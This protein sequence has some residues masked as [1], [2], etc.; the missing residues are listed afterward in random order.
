MNKKIENSLDYHEKT[1]HS[2][3]SVMNS[4]HYLDWNNRPN[5]FKIYVNLTSLTLP[6]KFPFPSMNAIRAIKG[7]AKNHEKYTVL[8]P[9]DH[10]GKSNNDS[11]S[12]R[13]TDISSI[14]FFTCGITRHVKFD[15]GSYYM[16]AASATGALYPIEVY[17]VSDSL[18]DD[19]LDAGIYHF[20]PGEFSLV[21]IRPGDHR[22]ILSSLAGN[23][24]D[25]L[26]S[27][28]SLVFTSNAGRNS[29]KYQS[30]S[31]R[32]WF[33]DTGVMVANLLAIGESM[34]LDIRLTLGFVDDH[35]NN[36]L[37]LET[38]KEAS[39]LIASVDI[40]SSDVNKI[41]K[42]VQDNFS[43]LDQTIV[44]PLSHKIYPLSIKQNFY[45]EIWKAY[46]S[47]KLFDSNEV[48]AWSKVHAINRIKKNP[49]QKDNK[50]LHYLQKHYLDQD[51]LDNK[52]PGIGTVIL[53]RGSTR[54]FSDVSI[55][56]DILS[57][58]LLNSSE[59][60]GNIPMDYKPDN[61]SLIEYYILVNSVEGLESG[62]Y[63]LDK[64][65][66]CL[67]FL[68]ERPTEDFSGH[69]CL[70][71]SLFENANVVI[72]LMA[73]LKFVLKILGNRGYRAAQLESGIIAGKIY[74]LSYACGIGASGS[75]FYDDEVN[76]F[77]CPNDKQM[78]TMIA[79]GVGVPSYKS[80]PGTIL[81]VRLSRE[82]M[83]GKNSSI[84]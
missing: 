76:A 27:P 1:K 57:T 84:F 32:H 18:P 41:D 2:Q 21:P 69:L 75:T 50:K 3:V 7:N 23:N 19:N 82:Q 54:R 35:V 77:F 39:V 42:F 67:E 30:R 48:T 36:L 24:M 10:E 61:S 11:K 29:W 53:K 22:N 6:T 14:L 46:D 25:I 59:A 8:D 58:I 78:A 73:D 52:M 37:G 40:T 74:L 38:H 71:Q 66:K 51:I 80:K 9:K 83:I 13:L 5:P 56:L 20:N 43:S 60:G 81:P 15:S 26:T 28:I 68:R 63:Y 79:V 55:P 64:D 72:F 12:I 62:A 17:L 44:E 45:P 49:E 47:S 65:A 31:Y 4:R 34:G 70:D 33:W 16:R